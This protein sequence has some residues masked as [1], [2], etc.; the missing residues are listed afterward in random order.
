MSQLQS[1]SKQSLKS[2]FVVTLIY[3]G[4]FLGLGLVSASL[5]PSLPSFAERTHVQLK[6]VSVLFT[7]V[8]LGYLIGAL[9]GGRVLD[10]RAGHPIMVAGLVISA[11]LMA[12]APLMPFLPLMAVVM[13][14]LGGS[15]AFVDVGGNT[16][17]VWLHREKVSPY[18]NG[19]HA[20]WGVG[21]I[22]SPLVISVAL[23]L[24]RKIDG[25]YWI[26]SLLLLLMAFLIKGKT[27]PSAPDRAPEYQAE[28]VNHWPIVILFILF[29]AT[30]VGGQNAYGGWIYSFAIARKIATPA[31]ASLMT[32]IYWGALTVS[33]LVSIP[34]AVRLKPRSMLAADI[35]GFILGLSLAILGGGSAALIW[36]ATILIG[37]SVGSFFPT[38]LSYASEILT[39]TGQFTSLI[40]V[41][42]SL[43]GMLL[44]WLIGQFFETVGPQSAMIIMLVDLLVCVGIFVLLNILKS[45]QHPE[46][47][48]IQ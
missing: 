42:V 6:Q 5:G 1:I 25:A 43:G 11:V 38:A 44:P 16:L 47:M 48:S 33:R 22:L 46:L 7:A 9:L 40:F 23:I 3:Y 29:F 15:Q 36:I 28:E 21:S 10:R 30:F 18:M 24:T 26:I 14:L 32:S 8:N 37:V 4:A 27:S 39:I 2:P 35:T 34:F 41:G 17:L 20:C 19:L 13:L 45:K 31:T 12:M